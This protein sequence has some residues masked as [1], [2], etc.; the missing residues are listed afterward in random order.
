[1][2]PVIVAS[3]YGKG[4]VVACGSEEYFDLRKTHDT[5]IGKLTRNIL[6]WITD[7]NEEYSERNYT[8]KYETALTKNKKIKIITTNMFLETDCSNHIEIVKVKSWKE[9]DLEPSKYAAAVVTK[10]LAY[11]EIEVLDRYIR[12]GGALIAAEK[13]W[14]LLDFPQKEV[15][16][17]IG[18]RPVKLGDYPL[19][20]L[21]NNAG[22][23]LLN[24]IA[25]WDD[26]PEKPLEP[27]TIKKVVNLHMLKLSTL[28]KSLE[29]NIISLEQLA[30]EFDYK[31]G[32]IKMDWVNEFICSTINSLCE[33]AEIIQSIKKDAESVRIDKLC[34]GQK[35][36]YSRMLQS[37]I[38]NK[39]TL[40]EDNCKSKL[41]DEFPGSVPK[42]A[43]RVTKTIEVDFSFQNLDYLKMYSAPNNWISTG[44]YAPAGEVVYVNIPEGTEDLDILIGAHIDDNSSLPEWKRVPVVALRKRLCA[45]ENRVNSPYGGLIYLIPTISKV[46]TK[47][48]VT[49]N[50]AVRA[51]YFILGKHSDHEWINTIRNYQAPWAEL[52]SERVI[53][54]LS[55]KEI[56]NLENPTELM[57]KWDEIVD[58]YDEFAGLSKDK[59]IPHKSPDRPFRYVSDKQIV[60]GWMHAGF[61][62]MLYE[63]VTS[64]DMV[65][66]DG[67]QNVRSGW[68]FWHEL[69]HNYQQ[70]AWVWDDVVEV[71]VNI[72]SLNMQDRYKNESR[73]FTENA[74]KNSFEYLNS[75][76]EDKDYNDYK[77]V[78]FFERLVMFRQL[79]LAYGWEFYT[80]LHIAY[81]ELSEEEQ[82]QN[83]QQKI[84]LFVYMACK[85]SGDNLLE[86]F[87]K[88]GLRYSPSAGEK[89]NKLKLP[90]PQLDVWTLVEK[91]NN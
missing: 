52:Q 40:N 43:E 35:E 51:P 15:Q 70:G 62:I 69:G 44:L 50:G 38:F 22:V 17:K 59:P 82:P 2:I 13:G 32:N 16:E 79:Q 75:S 74:Y 55:S 88:W 56:R 9:V 83:K 7:Y 65:T 39:V 77:Q 49:I 42:E 5:E 67:I 25:L 45:G 66:I 31:S 89:V 54:T 60:A 91:S 72:H 27:T 85:I 20:I 58:A 61:P 3:R 1:L 87:N 86:F 73:L 28:V 23:G 29:K 53:L 8:N 4:R 12:N 18:D 57:K 76:R 41:S 33:K 71:T 24:N 14:E 11:D 84:D 26:D 6:T 78:G 30:Y 37:Y 90:K 36:P 21:L 80:K 48:Q 68:G 64:R 19:Q 63:G 10:E 81:R 47:V 46:D 34:E